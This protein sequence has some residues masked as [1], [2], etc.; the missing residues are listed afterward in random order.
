MLYLFDDGILRV[1]RD[2]VTRSCRSDSL[3]IGLCFIWSFYCLELM[4]TVVTSALRG[5]A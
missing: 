5:H 2:F 1:M 3:R 4:I